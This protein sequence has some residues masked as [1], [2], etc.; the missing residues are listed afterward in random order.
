MR[1]IVLGFMT[2]PK[3]LYKI[4]GIVSMEQ[5]SKIKTNPF[6]T[7]GGT[8]ALGVVSP[9]PDKEKE[10]KGHHSER[11]SPVLGVFVVAFISLP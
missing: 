9:P 11:P 6:E 1:D 3:S 7:N 2:G 8:R 4:R 5:E 10:G